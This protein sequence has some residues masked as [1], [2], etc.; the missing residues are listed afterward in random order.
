MNTTE[1]LDTWEMV[2]VHRLFRREF[3]L[4]SRLITGV[5]DSD[6]RRSEFVGEYL[7]DLTDG[8]HHHHA[9]HE[10]VAGLLVRTAELLPTWR[11][12]ADVDTRDE[13]ADVFDML[14]LLL[15]EHLT[16]EETEWDALGKRG[17]QSL[18]KGAKGFVFLGGIMAE[19]T[20]EE[21]AAVLRRLPAPV[22]MLW[23]LVGHRHYRRTMAR[24]HGAV[25]KETA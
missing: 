25:Q 18:P 1:V 19:A 8:L 5:A 4:A 10:E 24:L 22:R 3:R 7:S 23:H 15:D 20:P 16:D 12:R 21:R 14:S 11:A 13:L 9:G 17:Q 2:L 6:R